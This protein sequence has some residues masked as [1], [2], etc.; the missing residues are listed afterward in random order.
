VSTAEADGRAGTR[1]ALDTASAHSSHRPRSTG[2]DPASELITCRPALC[3]TDLAAHHAIRH[4][5]FVVE[6]HVF[7]DSERDEHDNAGEVIHLLGRWAGVPAGAVRLFPLDTG[8]GLWQG[9]RLCV[10]RPYRVRGL[11][12]PLVRGAVAQAGALGGARMVAHIQLPNVPF[13]THLGW[14]VHGDTELYAGFEHQ[15]MVIDL[16]GR[17]EGARVAAELAEGVRH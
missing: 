17:A 13:F 1:V 16:P 12:S 2:E 7:A 4:E 9:D 6:Q 3:G 11:G 8:T 15:P 10:L 5:V 14:Q